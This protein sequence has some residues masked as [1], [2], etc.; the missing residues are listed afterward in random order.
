MTDGSNIRPAMLWLGA[1]DA[2]MLELRDE[3]ID[4]TLRPT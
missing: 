3:T 4:L 1:R 2:R